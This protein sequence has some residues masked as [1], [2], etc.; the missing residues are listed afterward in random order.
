MYLYFPSIIHEHLLD[1]WEFSWRYSGRS[2][3]RQST[4]LNRET[5]GIFRLRRVQR[6]NLSRVRKR[7]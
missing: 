4:S 5:R 2:G 7:H 1:N 3:D 6:L